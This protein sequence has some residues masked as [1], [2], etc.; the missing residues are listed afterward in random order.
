MHSVFRVTRQCAHKRRSL[1]ALAEFVLDL[2]DDV[3]DVQRL[4]GSLKDGVSASGIRIRIK[5]PLLGVTTNRD[6]DALLGPSP[7]AGEQHASTLQGL[8]VPLTTLDVLLESSD[9][10]LLGGD[11]LV[12]VS[13]SIHVFPSSTRANRRA[14]RVRRFLP[15]VVSV[16]HLSGHLSTGVDN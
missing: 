1:W 5:E 9:H 13:H 4:P 10:S 12:D 8:D 15:E 14:T 6:G 2:R 3:I 11:G 7:F 16:A